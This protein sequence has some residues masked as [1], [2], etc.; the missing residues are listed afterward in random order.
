MILTFKYWQIRI[1][2]IE[3]TLTPLYLA[4]DHSKWKIP[5]CYC[6]NYANWLQKC[7]KCV[8]TILGPTQ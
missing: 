2:H 3:G 6:T 7:I 1:S 5:G 4:G 8:T